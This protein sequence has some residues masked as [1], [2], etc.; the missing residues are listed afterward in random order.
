MIIS[1]AFQ[2]DHVSDDS[3]LVA[4]ALDNYV[5]VQP[6]R[7][8]FISRGKTAQTREPL[9]KRWDTIDPP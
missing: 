8:L 4:T 6:A 2:V 5:P 7:C 9:V 3:S 1:G